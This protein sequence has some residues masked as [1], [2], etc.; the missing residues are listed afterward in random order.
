ML[1][2]SDDNSLEA[3]RV[4]ALPSGR[5]R[6][7]AVPAEGAYDPQQYQGLKVPADMENVFQYIMK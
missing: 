6:A 4:P 3:A 5:R 7:V 2:D 1:P